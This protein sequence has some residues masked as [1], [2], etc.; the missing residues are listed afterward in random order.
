MV[1]RVIRFKRLARSFTYS[2]RGLAKVFREEQ[3]FR[4]ELAAGAVVLGVALL[5]RVSGVELA[6]LIVVIGIVLLMEI[7]N[8]I[9]EAL[10]DLLKP[11]LDH[12]VKVIKDISAAAVVVASLTA[13][14]V[15]LAIFSRYL[16]V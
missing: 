4:I 13:I 6:I 2:F 11:K 8:T 14:G 10:T 7:M 1:G 5:L 15:G 3:N 16:F 9:I 12:Y